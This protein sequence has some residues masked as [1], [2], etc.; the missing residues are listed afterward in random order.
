MTRP[1]RPDELAGAADAAGNAAAAEGAA[2]PAAGDMGGP[3]R[4]I[5]GI[6][7]HTEPPL[8]VSDTR[9]QLGVDETTAHYIVAGRKALDAITTTDGGTGTTVLE[10]LIAGSVGVA[11]NVSS[12]TSDDGG[13][14]ADDGIDLDESAE[15]F[16]VIA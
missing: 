7:L 13:D 12:D 3:T 10:H 9:H 5:S 1:A 2:A 8:S 6:L 15:D 4:S 14:E 16:E 11:R